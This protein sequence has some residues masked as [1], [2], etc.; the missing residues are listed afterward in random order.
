MASRKEN[1][2]RVT[3]LNRLLGFKGYNFP[4]TRGSKGSGKQF[5]LGGEYGRQ[6]LAYKS[7]KTYKRISANLTSGEMEEFLIGYR[8]GLTTKKTDFK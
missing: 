5:E 7:S 1:E 6:Y 2:N 4:K 8:S 3:G